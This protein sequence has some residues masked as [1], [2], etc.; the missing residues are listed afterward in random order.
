MRTFILRMAALA[1]LVTLVGCN[2][3][4]APAPNPGVKVYII[5]PESLSGVVGDTLLIRARAIPD[6]VGGL[7]ALYTSDAG[8]VAVS[9]DTTVIL[10]KEGTAMLTARWTDGDQVVTKTI[11]VTVSSSPWVIFKVRVGTIKGDVVDWSKLFATVSWRVP[12]K[13]SVT[14]PVDASG[15]ASFKVLREVAVAMDSVTVTVT[16]SSRH[17]NQSHNFLRK[18]VTFLPS[19]TKEM[20][21]Q[22]TNSDFSSTGGDVYIDAVHATFVANP[23]FRFILVPVAFAPS[24]GI[25]AGQAVTVSPVALY[26][27]DFQSSK[28]WMS[29]IPFTN[30]NWQSYVDSLPIRVCADESVSGSVA[31]SVAFWG[32]VNDSLNARTGKTWFVPAT[33]NCRAYWG[34][35][36]N[37]SG[38]RGKVSIK[39]G[40]PFVELKYFP[41]E[42]NPLDLGAVIPHEFIHLLGFGHTLGW[43]SVMSTDGEKSMSVA[44]MDNAMLHLFYELALAEKKMGGAV[45]IEATR[46]YLAMRGQWPGGWRL[47]KVAAG[48][49]S[50]SEEHAP[51]VWHCH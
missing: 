51:G 20:M 5:A 17:L 48:A 16:G 19:W 26:T 1:V 4:N 10:R 30:S 49:V 15:Y 32:S 44:P 6:T 29:G 46:Q 28:G 9:T 45:S 39:K 38:A 8:A 23:E 22:A 2:P 7:V 24:V 31:D 42:R 34:V 13:D 14:G 11:P 27:P 33:T 47:D 12:W 43:V 35:N 3:P 36:P 21:F 41:S 18:E 40:L 25:G 50:E 37:L